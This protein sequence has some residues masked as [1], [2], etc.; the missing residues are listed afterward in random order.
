MIKTLTDIKRWTILDKITN[1][2]YD[3]SDKEFSEGLLNNFIK[4]RGQFIEV[5]HG[6][7]IWVDCI[8]N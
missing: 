4:L 6:R 3:I 7:K 2:C 1:R 5:E 8:T